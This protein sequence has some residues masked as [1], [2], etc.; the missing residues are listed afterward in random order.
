MR[1]NP[2]IHLHSF[3]LIFNKGQK[4]SSDRVIFSRDKT[5]FTFSYSENLIEVRGQLRREIADDIEHFNQCTSGTGWRKRKDPHAV[6]MARY[7]ASLNW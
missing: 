7:G 5:S 4:N 1:Q 2:S 6:K 3:I